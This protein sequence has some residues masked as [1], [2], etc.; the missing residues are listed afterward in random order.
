MKLMLMSDCLPDA[1]T[2]RQLEDAA[3]ALKSRDR[4]QINVGCGASRKSPS[5]IR[6]TA[7]Q[8]WYSITSRRLQFP[9]ALRPC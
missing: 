5:A 9:L 8:E 6:T 2:A 3:A 4:M 7:Q 1:E